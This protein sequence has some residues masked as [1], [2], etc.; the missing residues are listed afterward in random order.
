[1]NDHSIQLVSVALLRRLHFL[2]Q[3]ALA[4]CELHHFA[5]GLRR[6]TIE[7]LLQHFVSLH[8]RIGTAVVIVPVNNVA[9]FLLPLQ[10]VVQ[11]VLLKLE[12]EGELDAVG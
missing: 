8:R 10:L 5:A 12:L 9:V 11:V 7:D 1:V 6:S 2:H 4:L 3:R